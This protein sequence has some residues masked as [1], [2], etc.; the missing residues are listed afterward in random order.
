MRQGFK[1][2]LCLLVFARW[3]VPDFAAKFYLIDK[4]YYKMDLLCTVTGASK[5]I[6]ALC[7]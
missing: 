6:T 4:I 7:F 1:V 3:R 2:G 5:T